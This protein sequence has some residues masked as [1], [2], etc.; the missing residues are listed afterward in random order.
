[1]HPAASLQGA[2]LH[3][4]SEFPYLQKRQFALQ[5]H[6][7]VSHVLDE[8]FKFKSDDFQAL[9]VSELKLEVNIFF[10]H[11]TE[12]KTIMLKSIEKHFM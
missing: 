7:S 2:D 1:M 9:Y 11:W 12:V 5:Y 8:L 4:V 10:I 6:V 3:L